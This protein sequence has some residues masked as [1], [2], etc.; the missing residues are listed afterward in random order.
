MTG[1]ILR[2]AVAAAVLCACLVW[3]GAAR[4][5]PQKITVGKHREMAATLIVPDGAGPFPAVL[6]LHTSG[7]LEHADI[8][9]AERLS[10]QGYVC[11]V[12]EFLDAY[13]ITPKTRDETFTTFAADIYDDFNAAI[14]TL[15][16]HPKVAGGK[17]G[18]VGFSNGGYFAMWLAATGKVAAGV[19]YYGAISGAGTDIP[20]DRFSHAFTASSSPV[21]ILHG[22]AD[23][24][25]LVG[26]AKHLARIL[27]Q[28]GAPH[29]LHLYEG[30][31]HRFDRDVGDDD[32][33]KAR[34]EDAWK[35]TLGFFNQHLKGR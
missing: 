20:L 9:F 17:V 28:V 31:D 25:V 21:L 15:E 27:K 23:G 33:A 35:R 32:A 5:E 1:K 18:A 24:T 13:G 7:G 4:A 22:T 29:E 12:P 16:R 26:A 11:L 34:A 19:S 8:A 2:A 14:A 6:V 10:R 30:A 3:G